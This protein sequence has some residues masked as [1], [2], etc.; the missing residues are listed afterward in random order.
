MLKHARELHRQLKAA[1]LAVLT[2]GETGK[3]HYR[4]V[5]SDGRRQVVQTFPKSPSDDRAMTNAFKDIVRALKR[6]ST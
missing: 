5:V 2:V 3:G 4:F 6:E 1:G